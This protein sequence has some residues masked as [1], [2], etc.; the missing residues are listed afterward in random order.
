MKRTP[1]LL[2]GLLIFLAILWL[3][4]CLVI[5]QPVFF[6]AARAKTKADPERLKNDV[7][8]LSENFHPRDFRHPENLDRCAAWLR[9]EFENAGAT[10]REQV[11][12]TGGRTYRNVI[13]RFGSRGGG[14]VV[15]G[16][17]YDAFQ[18]TPGADDNASGVAGLLELARLLGRHPPTRDMELVAYT[19][20]EPPFFRTADMGSAHHARE[21]KAGGTPVRGV[22]ILEMIGYFSNDRMSQSYPIPL[23]RLFYPSRGNFIAIAGRLD[24]RRFTREVK[25]GM[26][27]ATPLPVWSI[28]AP[29]SLPGLDFSDHRN[30]WA[31]GWDAVMITDTS[32]YR[33]KLYHEDGDTWDRLDYVRMADVV[34]AVYEAAKSLP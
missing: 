24:Q 34:T 33:N 19:L 1:R 10:V 23:L 14:L 3:A 26:K 25:A 22:M 11:F 15:V 32:F 28:N 13:A 9:M 18:D 20:E 16:A 12:E 4:V 8:A 2:I 27:G 7:R 21:L 31:E 29:A 5:V 6:H 17:H 30:Y